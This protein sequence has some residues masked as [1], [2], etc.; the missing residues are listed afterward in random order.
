MRTLHAWHVFWLAW[1][2]TSFFTFLGFEIY[3]LCTD[4]RRTLSAAVW[5]FED[6]APGQPI[7][8][9]TALHFLFGGALITVFVWL[10]GHFL[11]DI[12]R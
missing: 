12:W 7:V 10:I 1:F 4:W 8:N 3:A 9:W 6:T 2:A 11:F 5:H